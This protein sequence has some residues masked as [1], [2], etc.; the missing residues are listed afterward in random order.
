MQPLLIQADR[1]R[2]GKNFTNH[3][4]KASHKDTVVRGET[5]STSILELFSFNIPVKDSSTA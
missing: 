1:N 5:M 4:S 2:A 3:D